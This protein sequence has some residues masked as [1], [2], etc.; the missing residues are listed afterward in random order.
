MGKGNSAA[1]IAAQLQ[2]LSN[3]ATEKSFQY[4][5]QEANTARAWQKEMSDT[6]HQREVE[7]LKKAGLNP[8][9]ASNNGA[10][11]YTTSS[12]S[13]QA[14]SA[15][16]AVGNVW[17]SDISARATR[18]AAAQSAAATRYAAAAQA[19]AARYAASLQ[20]QANMEGFKVS[21]DNQKNQLNI[22]KLNNQNKLDIID[23]TPPSKVTELVWKALDQSGIRKE[24]VNSN[25]V[26]GI[27]NTVSGLS[28]NPAKFFQQVKGN[29][30]TDKNF[31]LNSSG[32][33]KVNNALKN[34]GL[35]PSVQA[36]KLFIKAFV[37]HDGSAISAIASLIKN[38]RR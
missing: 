21:R 17:S 34:M 32:V 5:T 36:Q 20:Y 1:S 10:Q 23:K 7:D 12:A 38:S 31:V 2:R 33:K 8:V 18:A 25:F 30:I 24:L 4:N 22:A 16:N 11:S 13:A 19:S 15:T 29:A 27:K 9:L 28:N 37:F 35:S 26:T 6:A 3:E 14:D